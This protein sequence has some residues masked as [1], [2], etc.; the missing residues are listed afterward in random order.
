MATCPECGA[1]VRR[2]NLKA[3]VEKVHRKTDQATEE[4]AEETS[5]TVR[6]RGKEE[7]KVSPWPAVALA[8]LLAVSSVGAY[9]YLTQHPSGSSG[10]G[11][12]PPPSQQNRKALVATSF[13]TFTI[14]LRE[15]RAP[16]TTGNFVRLAQQGFYDGKAFHRVVPGFVIQGGKDPT[17]SVQS[18]PWENTGLPNIAYSVAMARVGDANSTLYKDTAT[19]EFFVNLAY[20]IN[21]DQF[22]YP[23]VVFGQVIAGQ[24]VVDAIGQ[25][26]VTPPE[27][28]RVTISSV[29]VVS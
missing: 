24:S 8:V 15:D 10:G 13:G 19:C 9:W 27:T 17:G 22:I 21:L 5:I 4:G 16:I 20:N 2:D 1:K 14:L 11:S 3:H 29:T 7:R 25:Y 12:P 28:P 26:A 6:R 18:V 23:Y